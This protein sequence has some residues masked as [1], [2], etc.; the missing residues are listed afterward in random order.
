MTIVLDGAVPSDFIPRSSEVV[1]CE[2]AATGVD[3]TDAA[4]IV[5]NTTNT[6]VLVTDANGINGV[7]LPDGVVG[8]ALELHGEPA[9]LGYKIYNPDG[10]F[11]GMN[12]FGER[13]LVRM[14]YGW[15]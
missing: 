3:D 15:S 12:N 7:R 5:T 1:Y 13:R 10:T 11:R 8:D 9:N 6:V 2:I 4:L 14:S